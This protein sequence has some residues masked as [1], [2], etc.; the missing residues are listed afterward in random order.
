MPFE[1]GFKRRGVPVQDESR[2]EL[3]PIFG[4]LGKDLCRRPAN[5]VDRAAEQLPQR[6]EEL[7]TNGQE[8]IGEQLELLAVA[9]ERADHQVCDQSGILL[10]RRGVAVGVIGRITHG[11]RHRSAQAST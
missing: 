11:Q 9:D 5:L 4:E 3:R 1:Q 2:Q 8:G 7:Q 6:T 10:P